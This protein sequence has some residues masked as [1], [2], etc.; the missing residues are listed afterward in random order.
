M[1]KV[2]SLFDGEVQANF[3]FHST[4]YKLTLLYHFLGVVT[5]SLSYLILYWIP[6][7]YVKYFTIPATEEHNILVF[8]TND[9][10]QSELVKVEHLFYNGL[11]ENAVPNKRGKLDYLNVFMYRHKRYIYLEGEVIK[12]EEWKDFDL[13]GLDADT[14]SQRSL[15]FGKNEILVPNPT[16]FQ[17]LVGEI[18]HPFYIFQMFSVVLWFAED[19]VYYAACILLISVVSVSKSL[20]DTKKNIRRLEDLAKSSILIEVQRSGSWITVDSSELCLGD[21]YK[22]PLHSIPADSILIQGQ[23]VVDECMLTGESVTVTKSSTSELVTFDL[24]H[25]MLNLN[26]QK[27]FIYNGT[28]VLQLQKDSVAMVIR[29]GYKTCKGMLIRS[30][31]HPKPQS[32]KFYQ[33]S[34]K[35]VVFLAGIALLGFLYSCVQFVTA[36]EPF[37]VILV[38]SLDLITIAVPPALPSTLTA[39]ISFALSRLSKIQIYCISPSRINVAGQVNF[40]LFDKTGTLT[41]NNLTLKIVLQYADEC[42]S[43]K[44]NI[45][46]EFKTIMATCHSLTS[47]N[48]I[49]CGDPL[50]LEMFGFTDALFINSSTIRLLDSEVEI[51]KIFDFDPNLRRMSVLCRHKNKVIVCTKGAPES[52]KEICG[53]ISSEFDE[54]LRHYSHSGYRVLACAIKYDAKVNSTREEIEKNLEFTGFLI[55][56]NKLKKETAD[57]IS[58]LHSAYLSTAMCTGDNLLTAISV[59]KECNILNVPNKMV[60]K[61]SSDIELQQLVSESDR[62]YTLVVPSYEDGDLVWSGFDQPEFKTN[63]P[64]DYEYLRFALDGQHFEI[65]K[66]IKSVDYTYRVLSNCSVYARMTP[67]QKKSV[68]EYLQ[69]YN[70]IVLFCGDG[71]N[72]C[73][74]LKASDVGL[75][76]SEAEASIAA[77][78]TS[79]NFEINCVL[80]L[81]KEG[82]AALVTSFGCFKYMALYSMTQ[83]FTVTILYSLGSNLS[84]FQFLFIDLFL[85]LPLAITMAY[86]PPCEKLSVEK[87]VIDLMSLLVVLP[88]IM[89]IITQAICQLGIYYIVQLQPFYT[90]SVLS[91]EDKS[92]MCYE[93]SSVFTISCIIYISFAIVYFMGRPYRLPIYKSRIFATALGISLTCVLLIMMTDIGDTMLSLNSMPLYYRSYMFLYGI[94]VF[95]VIWSGENYLF[96]KLAVKLNSLRSKK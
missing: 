13:R 81:I 90:P 85:V 89:Q 74:A 16:I 92:L 49:M 88:L 53:S 64:F 24:G 93:S 7:L 9:W 52:I 56:E 14:A 48:N 21:L 65:V 94:A 41:I 47:I 46:L 35:F 3:S 73:A 82:R 71:A 39:G 77:P 42:L 63:N 11:T 66:A 34:V 61:T 44:D 55:F 96:V 29:T 15:S 4:S 69:K 23:C 38:A 22:V 37:V 10:K 67:D 31:L 43:I 87:P 60:L 75:S 25:P 83:F 32:Y 20:H 91:L 5:F 57:T 59:A 79:K 62:N 76:L 72:D 27:H 28:T 6:S 78:F 40:I 8:I 45:S 80:D 68:V 51:L 70:N 30:I 12:Q 84:D 95:L 33:D 54:Q 18:L 17:L 58:K 50:E 86:S 36:G 2:H 19:Y 1:L 26:L